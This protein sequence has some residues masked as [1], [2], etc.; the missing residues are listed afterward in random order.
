M[1]FLEACKEKCGYEDQEFKRR[2]QRARNSVV[3]KL[4]GQESEEE[5]QK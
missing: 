2:Q 1:L 4:M 3:D 5:R